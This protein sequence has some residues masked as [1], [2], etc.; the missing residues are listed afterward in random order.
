[1]YDFSAIYQATSVKHALELLDKHKQA[2]VLAGGSDVLI[3]A[4]EGHLAGIEVVSIYM[5]DEL[6]GISFDKDQNI[7]IKPLTSFSHIEQND[8]IKQH[9]PALAEAVG[10][11][12]GPQI[13]NIGSIG[14][15]LCNGVTSAD[16]A[17]TVMAYDALLEIS[18]VNG[19]RTL[20]IKEFY[21]GPGKVD[22]KEGEL[23]TAIIIPKQS[24]QDTYGK[25]IKYAMR[26]AMDIATL[27]CSVNV[28]LSD[29]KQ[30][31]ERLRIAFGVAAATPI[32]TPKTEQLFENAK[33][34]P[35]MIEKL[36]DSALSE[37]SPRSSWRAS[38]EL[39]LQIASENVKRAFVSAIEQTGGSL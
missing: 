28:R 8:I 1:M 23:L 19:Q 33:L 20:D 10:Q 11:V 13:R 22:L 39:R 37:I 16:S 36:V 2:H 4:R 32:R 38:K 12:G 31:V 34:E 7:V 15:N 21:K 29:D 26:K 5:L 30:T 6:R 24:Y 9:L 18:S 25:Y 35:N 27:G 3:K 17:S 14:G